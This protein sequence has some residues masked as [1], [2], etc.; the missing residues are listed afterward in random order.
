MDEARA[1]PW[2]PDRRW[3]DPLITLLLLASLLSIW[4]IFAAQNAPPA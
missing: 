1:T 2:N 4:G 3:A